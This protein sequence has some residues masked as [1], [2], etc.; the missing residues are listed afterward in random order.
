[1]EFSAQEIGALI[2]RWTHILFAVIA[3]GGVFFMR[4]VVHGAAA[5]ALDEAG[6]KALRDAV[7]KRWKRWVMISIPLLL[8]SG[9]YNYLVVTRHHHS[10]QGLYHALFGV[11]FLLALGFFMLGS[12]LTGRAK[13]FNRLRERAPLWQ[14]VLIALGVLIILIAG[15]MKLIPPAPAT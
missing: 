2:S 12:V 14:G 7:L 10:G 1:M 5:E 13:V 6:H 15:V 9:L 3:V 8:A 11:K 4:F